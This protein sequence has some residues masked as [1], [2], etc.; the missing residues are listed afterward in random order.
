[1]EEKTEFL[2]TSNYCIRCYTGK[3]K[4]RVPAEVVI[5]G[6][7]C[8]LECADKVLASMEQH[9][10]EMEERLKEKSKIIKPHKGLRR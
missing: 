5:Q 6:A 4:A 3:D 2:M 7:S 10:K 8:C 9:A 1:M